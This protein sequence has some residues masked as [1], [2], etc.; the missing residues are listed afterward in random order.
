[1]PYVI[2]GGDDSDLFIAL[3][4]T[5]VDEDGEMEVVVL[6]ADGVEERHQHIVAYM[7]LYL[8]ALLAGIERE[9]A[10]RAGLE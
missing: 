8:A 3:D 1:M 2:A 7:E 5:K 6:T 10:D 4:P 9:R